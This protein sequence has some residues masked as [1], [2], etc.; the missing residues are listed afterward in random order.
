MRE[1]FP[2]SA[3]KLKQSHANIHF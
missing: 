2:G 1:I 3:I